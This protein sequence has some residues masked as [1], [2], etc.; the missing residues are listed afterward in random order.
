MTLKLL[1]VSIFRRRILQRFF[2][3]VPHLS[4][5][6]PKSVSRTRFQIFGFPLNKSQFVVDRIKSESAYGQLYDR[7][8]ARHIRLIRLLPSNKFEADIRCE[9]LRASLNRHPEYEALSY[10]WGNPKITSP[11][12]LEGVRSHVTTN[13]EQA[14][15]H[16]RYEY[17][18][19]ILWVDALSI[20]QRDLRERNSQVRKMRSIYMGAKR[21]LVWLGLE[22]DAKVALG[23]CK[24][25]H[26]IRRME[27]SEV[28]GETGLVESEH[29]YDPW[30][31]WSRYE[32]D[33]QKW[34]ACEALFMGRSWWSRT[35][36]IQEVLHGGRVEF[37]YGKDC[38]LFGR[39]SGSL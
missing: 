21:V 14:L 2:L 37:L 25:L 12:Y 32:K 5:L 31:V 28:Y 9:I 33:E 36:I 3:R 17:R 24:E 27:V 26:K 7:P 10:T 22:E 4:A 23:F 35:W 18:E 1:V 30:A 20:N 19:R 13:L 16:L 11:V 15:R 8:W 39:A 29:A 34:K 38:C 6:P